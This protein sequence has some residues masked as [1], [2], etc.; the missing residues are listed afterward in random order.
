MNPKIVIITHLKPIKAMSTIMM[1]MTITT[2][3]PTGNLRAILV[4]IED[5][6]RDQRPEVLIEASKE[7]TDFEDANFHSNV[8]R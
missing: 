4:Q 7:A 1:K 6:I 2:K 3:A 8:L 5:T